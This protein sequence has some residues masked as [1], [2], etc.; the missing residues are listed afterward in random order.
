MDPEPEYVWLLNNDT[1][2]EPDALS[3]MM[4]VADR[5]PTVGIVGSHLVDADGSRRTQA[6]GGGSI[7]RWLGTTSTY[8]APTSK[9]C[10]HLVGASLL[11]RCAMLHEV[12]GFDERYFFYLEDTDLSVRARR[13]GWQLRVAP[14][15]IVAHRR[16]AT[17]DGGGSGRSLQSDVSLARSS[18]LFVSSLDLPWRITAIPIRLTAMIVRRLMRR[19]WRRVL[20]MSRAY[21]AG[22]ILGGT[23]AR[24]PKFGSGSSDATAPFERAPGTPHRYPRRP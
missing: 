12:G 14:Q 24:I 8:T 6:L 11:L 10:E 2:V 20:P 16:G 15:A 5:E 1:L 13:A 19:Q 23:A 17:I 3:Q 9:P 21:V 22:V 18:G 4:A 7:N